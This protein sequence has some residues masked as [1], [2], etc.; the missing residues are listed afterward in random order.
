MLTSNIGIDRHAWKRDRP[1][2]TWEN[3][4]GE[5]TFTFSNGISS[6]QRLKMDGFLGANKHAKALFT[7]AKWNWSPGEFTEAGGLG[8]GMRLGKV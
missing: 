3:A 4:D 5:E 7:A 6:D 1:S 8:G 2:T